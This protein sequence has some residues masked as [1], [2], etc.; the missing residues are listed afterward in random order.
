MFWNKIVLSICV[1]PNNWFYLDLFFAKH[2]SKSDCLLRLLE[3]YKM[4]NVKLK[5]IFSCLL[6]VYLLHQNYTRKVV[7]TL[8]IIFSEK[9]LFN[10]LFEQNDKIYLGANHTQ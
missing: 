1:F 9:K 2:K 5:F 6:H 10:S 8:I 3:Y 7:Q 4:Q